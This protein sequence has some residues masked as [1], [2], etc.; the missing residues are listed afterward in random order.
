MRMTLTRGLGIAWL[1]V[2]GGA[3]AQTCS[4]GAD[5]GMDA[6][7]CLCNDSRGVASPAAFSAERIAP[8]AAARATAPAVKRA[9]RR[10]PANAMTA[11][12]KAQSR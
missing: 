3:L 4:G 8:A 10:T 1:A 9:K 5:G 12:V 6:T 2:T 11:L 7:G